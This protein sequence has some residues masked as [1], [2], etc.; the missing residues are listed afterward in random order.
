MRAD[1]SALSADRPGRLRAELGLHSA[2]Q[3][4]RTLCGRP[5]GLTASRVRSGRA[6]VLNQPILDF[7]AEEESPTT[8]L[9]ARHHSAPRPVLHGRLGDTK[10]L[11]D[12]YSPQNIG[13][14]DR[15]AG[16]GGPRWQS[17]V[18]SAGAHT[19]TAARPRRPEQLS[20]SGAERPSRTRPSQPL[21][22]YRGP[23]PRGESDRCPG[24]ARADNLMP[25]GTRDRDGAH[26]ASR[27]SLDLYSA[28]CSSHSHTRSW[29]SGRH[30]AK[31]PKN[32][33]THR[34]RRSRG[35]PHRPDHDIYAGTLHN[36]PDVD[37]GP[38]HRRRATKGRGPSGWPRRLNQSTATT[39][40]RPSPRSARPTPVSWRRGRSPLRLTGLDDDLPEQD[41]EELRIV[42]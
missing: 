19:S 41:D 25:C 21:T 10:D 26:S 31:K 27:V 39:A 6:L 2:L 35:R 37:D 15:T 9:S 24:P 5:R 4:C 32:D 40:R 11:R 22:R 20:R 30:M 33:R 3:H 28:R 13:A 12:L 42:G 29:P 34:Q 18:G 38:R 36:V 23:D 17:A 7:P 8:A 1:A 14:R 16:V